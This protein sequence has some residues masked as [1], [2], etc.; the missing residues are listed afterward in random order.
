M[1]ARARQA[2]C[3]GGRFIWV[4]LPSKSAHFPQGGNGAE[5][6][7]ADNC[8]LLL[9]LFLHVVIASGDLRI[10]SP[11]PMFAYS[12]ATGVQMTPLP[13]RLQKRNIEYTKGYAI[14]ALCP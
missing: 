7:E 2:L 10:M 11:E 6:D 4:F 9:L 13:L 5:P 3:P 14:K 12:P 1:T 8:P